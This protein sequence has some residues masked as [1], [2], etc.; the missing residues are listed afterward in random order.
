MKVVDAKGAVI[1][2]TVVVLGALL[3][4]S[5]SLPWGLV[6]IN[7]GE[8]F[9]MSSLQGLLKDDTYSA[10]RMHETWDAVI[11]GAAMVAILVN[12][13][14]VLGRRDHRA[15]SAA[16]TIAAGAVCVFAV[17]LTMVDPPTPPVVDFINSFKGS[18]LPKIEMH[19]RFGI[20]ISLALAVALLVTGLMQLVG[21]RRAVESVPVASG[22]L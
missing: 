10:W 5:M 3:V 20:F 9:L 6:H 13:R 7:L 17:V 16:V 11:A 4:L 15:V 22:E 12:L 8:S 1:P 19:P 14:L 2:T 18:L 21:A